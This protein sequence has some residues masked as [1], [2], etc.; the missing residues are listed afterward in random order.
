MKKIWLKLGIS[1]AIGTLFVW[2]AVRGVD[3]AGVKKVF[4]EVDLSIVVLYFFILTGIHLVRII[5]W[6]L[7]LKPLGKIGFHRLF[8]VGSVG[9]LALTLLPMRLGEFARPMLISEKGDI[10]MSSALA[11]V[12]VERVVD[13]LAVAIL[14]LVLLFSLEGTITIPVEV[15][16]W[17]CVLV[18]LFLLLLVF[19]IMA[20]R[21]QEWTI[22]CFRKLLRRLPEKAT[23]KATSTLQSFFQGLKALPS[24]RLV[25]GFLFLTVIYWVAAGSGILFV[26]G[27]F[28]GLNQLGW[29][30][31]FTVFCFLCVGQLIPA[32]PGMIGNFH[33]FAVIGL[34]L[35][36]PSDVLKTSGVAFAILVHALQLGMQIVFGLPLL[37]SKQISFERILA[38]I[39]RDKKPAQC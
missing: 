10:R 13:S 35:F 15:R 6:G 23:E 18:V 39:K 21:Y 32:G 12:V 34:S 26:F 19:L 29:V 11:T 3:W 25:S 36:V 9:L 28:P 7:L 8:V 4:S 31:A 24:A 30:E 17:A 33:Y 27:A 14:L 2:L 1:V 37:F 5:R 20:Y 16:S 22:Q 38:S